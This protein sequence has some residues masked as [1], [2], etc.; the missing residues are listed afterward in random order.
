[1][2]YFE[3]VYGYTVFNLSFPGREAVRF[4]THLR[5]TDLFFIASCLVDERKGMSQLSDGSQ[6]GFEE[7]LR[8]IAFGNC[9]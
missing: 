3:Y 8:S 1:M 4:K 5:I 2:L 9:M 7:Q 6:Q